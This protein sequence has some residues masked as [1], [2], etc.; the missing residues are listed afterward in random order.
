MDDKTALA[1]SK[2]GRRL[3]A[4][5]TLYNQGDFARLQTYFDD[6]YEAGA[7]IS[8]P[9]DR[10]L[11]DLKTA[12]KLHGRLRVQQV[13]AAD[14]HHVIALLQAEK[15][16]LLLY[17]LKVQEDYPHKVLLSS[18]KPAETKDEKGSL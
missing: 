6:N 1:K 17:E 16:A 11:F 14:E 13:V 10:R 4:Q 7:L 8:E 18:L 9:A 5:L 3:I 15:G 2:A 12:H